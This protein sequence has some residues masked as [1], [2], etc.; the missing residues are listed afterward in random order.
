MPLGKPQS[1]AAMRQRRSSAV[2]R[3]CVLATAA[4]IAAPPAFAQRDAASAA[5]K[6]GAMPAAWAKEA[7]VWTDEQKA[8]IAAEVRLEFLHAWRGYR[9]YAWGH[10]ELLPLS[11]GFKDWYGTSLYMTPVDSLDTLILMGLSDEA[12][13]TRQLI[14]KNLSFDKDIYVK[15]F[16]ITIRMMGG[17]LSSYQLTGDRRLLALA[18]DLGRRLLPAFRSSTGTPYVY[19]NL[20]TGKVRGAETNPAEIGTLLLE[21][22]T[23]SKLTGNPIYYSKAKQALVEVYNRRSRLGLPG[24][25]IN[26]E[27]GKWSNTESHISGGIDSYYEYLLKA[28]I[29]FGDQDCERMWKQS[30]ASV[31]QYVAD[32]SANGLWYG[33][34]DMFTGA[35]TTSEFGALDAFFPAV[36]ALSRD[37]D[38]SQRLL[39]SCYKMWNVYGVE[40]E[41]FDYSALKGKELNYEL[42]P[43]IIESTYYVYFFTGDPKYLRMGET[44]LHSLMEYCRTDAAYAALSNV[45]TKEKKDAMES[46][47]FAETLKY[48]YLLYAPK[49][50]LDLRKVVFNTEAHPLQRTWK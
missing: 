15:N 39:D 22:G 48:L 45:E 7:A 5:A 3:V 43:E 11:K 1:E 42:R 40:P 41:S 38:R 21:F 19:V 34:V 6:S 16:E 14:V 12:N 10:D 47:F 37:L 25:T 13:E 35:R 17:L 26:V 20:R 8:L 30:I 44:Y 32:D 2:M 9:Q 33:H 24:S 50:T 23:L 28:W 27:T 4:L 31:N 18:E 36:L 46:F 29:L 49:T